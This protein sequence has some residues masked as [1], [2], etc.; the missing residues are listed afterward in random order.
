MKNV[1]NLV[2]IIAIVSLSVGCKNKKSENNKATKVEQ[3]TK[4]EPAK[5]Q[6]PKTDPLKIVD[7]AKSGVTVKTI[8]DN[9]FNAIGGITKIKKV[10]TLCRH[11]ETKS[12]GQT[13][14]N[15]G[16]YALPNKIMEEVLDNKGKSFSRTSFD[17]EK[18]IDTYEGKSSTFTKTE[19][20][21][22]FDKTSNV[23]FPDF[24]YYK[25][26]L[27]GIA[28]VKGER[29]YVINYKDYNIYYSVV[30]GLKILYLKLKENKDKTNRIYSK[31]S[32]EDYQDV[33][34]IKIPFKIYIKT[35]GVAGS[36]LNVKEVYINENVSDKD[37]K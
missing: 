18:G 9:Y 35:S 31:T 4:L 17:G 5:K 3:S 32:Y 28:E 13:F 33:D 7:K 15:I 34:G 25:G 1:I 20:E 16:K 11:Y 29:A 22:L 2:L 30:T 23:I 36:T 8:I 14:L 26:K 21:E 10:K 19:A 37:F 12:M 6:R 27:E 24:D